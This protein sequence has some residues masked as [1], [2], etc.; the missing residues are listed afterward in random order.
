MSLRIGEVAKRAGTTT[1]TVRYYEEIGLLPGSSTRAQGKHR[2]FT[3]ADVER[4]EEILRMRDLLNLSLEELK[5]LVEAED[6]RALLR[7][8][9]QRTKDRKRRRRILEE[10]LGHITR[11]LELV[12]GRK[13]ELA[14]LERQLVARRRRIKARERELNTG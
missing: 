5:D 1:R 7:E 14:K 10:A 12:R 9:F 8:E 11:Q 4:L 2:S 13:S 3:T 6:A